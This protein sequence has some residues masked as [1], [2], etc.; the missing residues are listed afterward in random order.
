MSKPTTP[1]VP[2]IPPVPEEGSPN[3][4]ARR[5][6]EGDPAAI[7]S[8]L[9]SI[10][11]AV[12]A[13]VRRILGPCQADADDAVQHTLIG[14]I[15]ALPAYRG[16]ADPTAY[17]KTIAVRSA[18]AFRRQAHFASARTDGSEDAGLLPSKHPSPSDDVTAEQRRRLVRQL[19]GEI[20]AEQAEA[21]A[22]R[23]VLGWSLEEIAAHSAVPL[24]TVRS[25]LRL[26]KEALRKR[27]EAAP[28]LQEALVV[29]D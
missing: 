20:P 4:V 13:V 11:P 3:D 14:F 12:V 1:A 27:I 23:V 29:G 21:L 8:V 19:L 18:L 24:N 10:R 22:M 6:A 28:G 26:A 9:R 5:A 7:A 2:F 25:R 16:D 17:A 15:R